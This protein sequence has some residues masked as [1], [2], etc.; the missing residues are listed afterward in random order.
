MNILLVE[1]DLQLGKAL[2]RGLEIA[3]FH[4]CWVRLL[5]DARVQLSQRPFDL[6]LLDLGLPDGDGQDELI[7]L[8]K[9][10]EKIPII[11]LTARTQID[12]LVQTLDSGADDFLPKPFCYARTYFSR[13][14]S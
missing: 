12:N 14:S 6:M 13:K 4:P 11:I 8:R 10:G 1:D 5:A 3:G 9:N 7:S 2:C